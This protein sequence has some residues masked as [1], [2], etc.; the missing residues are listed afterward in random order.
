MGKKKRRKQVDKNYGKGLGKEPKMESGKISLGTF[1]STS[2]FSTLAR[3]AQ[4]PEFKKAKII[5]TGVCVSFAIEDLKIAGLA[6]PSVNK[7]GAICVSIYAYS[8]VPELPEIETDRQKRLFPY[9]QHEVR[10]LVAEAYKRLEDEIYQ[11]KFLRLD[12]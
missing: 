12:Y 10:R 5:D 1:V 9:F 2:D 8:A 4:T 3:I 6:F 7:D 11:A